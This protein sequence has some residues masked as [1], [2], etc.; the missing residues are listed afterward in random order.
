M[1]P[2]YFYLV[3]T[4]KYTTIIPNLSALTSV[5][6]PNQHHYLLNSTMPN[7]TAGRCLTALVAVCRHQCLFLLRFIPFVFGQIEFI[8]RWRFYH[9][10]SAMFINSF[11]LAVLL[12]GA[13]DISFQGCISLAIFFVFQYLRHFCC[14]RHTESILRCSKCL[15][16]LCTSI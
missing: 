14:D 5:S 1:Q 4:A 12:S 7:G 10:H 11:F 3:D 9:I 15:E 8:F 2:P 16:T 13:M 6:T